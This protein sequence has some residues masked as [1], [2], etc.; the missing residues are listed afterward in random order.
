MCRS[1]LRFFEPVS[2]NLSNRRV[3]E[4]TANLHEL[5]SLVPNRFSSSKSSLK[6]ENSASF[7]TGSRYSY[8]AVGLDDS[9][10]L[11]NCSEM[12]AFNDRGARSRSKSACPGGVD[13][14]LPNLSVQT[15]FFPISPSETEK[16]NAPPSVWLP[17]L[18]FQ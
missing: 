1:E 18:A 8:N 12:L 9:L 11:P 5:S 6:Y 17:P 10:G 14:S 16:T 2:Y 4:S 3:S 15:S 7:K 13:I